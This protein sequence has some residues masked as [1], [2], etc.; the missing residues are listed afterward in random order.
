MHQTFS[1]IELGYIQRQ[2]GLSESEV[3]THEHASTL[4][5][6]AEQAR[7]PGGDYQLVRNVIMGG[8]SGELV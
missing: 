3:I 5:A 7:K 2:A 8:F 1:G 4:E 6:Y